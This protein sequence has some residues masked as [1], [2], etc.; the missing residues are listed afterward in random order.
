MPS[1]NIRNRFSILLWILS[2]SSTVNF[3]Q[4]RSSTGSSLA[5]LE[6][7]DH[8]EHLA[9]EPAI[10]Q[11]PNGN[12][13]VTG[14]AADR[15]PEPQT[16]PRLWKSKDG[17]TTW[18]LVNVG[19]EKEGALANSDVSLAIAP[20]GTIYLASMRFDVKA[21]EGVH[22][23]V[24]VSKDDGQSWRWKM[25]S[26]KRFDDR[27]WVA[28]SPDGTA[29]VIWNDGS[30]VHRVTSSDRGATW[31]DPQIVHRNGGSSYLAVGPN[32]EIAVRVVPLSASGNM[33]SEGID[34]I[35]I[36]YDRGKT[37][38]E[39]AAP[40]KRDWAPMGTEGTVPRWVE[41]LAWGPNSELYSLWTDIKGVWVA[42]SADHG[43]TWKF[44]KVADVDALS[45]YPDL[46]VRSS[47]ELAATWVSGAGEAL[48]WRACVIR[49]ERGEDEPVV[50]LSE[51]LRIKSWSKVD[52]PDPIF[53]QTAAG[54]YLQ[55]VFLEDGTLSVVT[56]IQDPK[57]DRYGFTF[58]KFKIR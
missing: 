47:G 52:A 4:T 5:P 38:Q 34:L 54:E 29:H 3:A 11:H 44:H 9:R 33:Y 6:S 48:R 57:A 23:V 58:W 2:V 28:V 24:G 40:G 12:L 55:P 31:S 36:S 14:Y 16:V 49:F 42:R 35:A 8:V 37:W 41:P 45:Y 15:E 17:G 39:I 19:G 1:S 20:D 13:F 53:V 43:A 32:G 7:V 56:P 25:L 30:A 18:S 51:P 21:G 26:K 10:R 46:A 27:P 22:I 50:A